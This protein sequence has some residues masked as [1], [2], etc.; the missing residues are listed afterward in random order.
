MQARPLKVVRLSAR[1]EDMGG[2]AIQLRDEAVLA[3]CVAPGMTLVVDLAKQPIQ[4]VDTDTPSPQ[5]VA[6]LQAETPEHPATHYT[7]ESKPWDHK[8]R[9]TSHTETEL[10]TTDAMQVRLKRVGVWM[11]S[12][13]PVLADV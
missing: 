12:L 13:T 4:P 6:T 8:N 9:N 7:P 5:Q 3:D 11:P 10:T 2:T 1:L